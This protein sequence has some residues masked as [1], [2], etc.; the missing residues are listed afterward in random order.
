[1]LST[2]AAR[3]VGQR[4]AA[5][6]RGL[7]LAQA[8]WPSTRA[9]VDRTVAGGLALAA[10]PTGI[11]VARGGTGFDGP[12]VISALALGALLAFSVED[13][14]EETLAASP[15]T[16]ARRRLV[17]LSALTFGGG[18]VAAI[19]LVVASAQG[20]DV[21]SGDLGRRGTELLAVSGLAIA[22]AATARRRAVPGAVHGGA[23]VAVLAVLLIS[24][25][26][27]RIRGLP[28]LLDDPEH[29]RWLW[30]A[31]VGWLATAWSWRDP[32]R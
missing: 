26:A 8:W 32:G 4:A 29:E 2:G 20:G 7:V 24:A 19:V 9:L 17:R 12:L 3:D 5:P 27:Y 21:R 31:A 15:T 10:L 23:A 13:P 16:L 14:A 30:V 28:A 6:R 11:V 18:V 25:L 22:A 1:V